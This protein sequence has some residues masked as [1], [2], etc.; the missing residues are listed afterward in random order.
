MRY[1][2][3]VLDVENAAMTPIDPQVV[4]ADVSSVLCLAAATSSQLKVLQPPLRSSLRF[5]TLP[6]CYSSIK[7]DKVYLDDALET[8]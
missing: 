8:V 5:Q 1:V 2:E 7:S 3:V 4:G 6:H